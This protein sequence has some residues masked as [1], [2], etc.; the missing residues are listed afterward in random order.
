[1]LEAR[2]PE[3]GARAS[4]CPVLCCLAEAGAPAPRRPTLGSSELAR[5]VFRPLAVAPLLDETGRALVDED[6]DGALMLC[7]EFYISRFE[8]Y[9]TAKQCVYIIGVLDILEDIWRVNSSFKMCLMRDP[10][11]YG[12]LNTALWT[13][14]APKR[15][16]PKYLHS[17]V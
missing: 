9:E 4:S 10:V 2:E 5:E 15:I 16:T 1:M 13:A 7:R 17:E 6:G 14:G 8:A 12:I 3:A 11:L